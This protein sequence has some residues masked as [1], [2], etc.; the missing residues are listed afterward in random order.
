MVF[1]DPVRI[2]D[3]LTCRAQVN[4]TGRSSMEVGVRVT[5]QRWDDASDS[6]HHVATAYLVFVAVDDDERP[7]AVPAVVPEG[8]LNARRSREAEIRRSARLAGREAIRAERASKGE[9]P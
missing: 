4:W 2:G 3:I 7:R 1:L 8:E 5:A 6:E 9:R